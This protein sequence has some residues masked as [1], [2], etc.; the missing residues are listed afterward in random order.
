M[1]GYGLLGKGPRLH[2]SLLQ[3]TGRCTSGA[4]ACWVRGLVFTR[5]RCRAASRRVCSVATSSTRT[6]AS[7]TCRRRC[8]A[9]RRSPVR[10]PFKWAAPSSAYF[11]QYYIQHLSSVHVQ[12][13]SVLPHVL[14]LQS[15]VD[16]CASAFIEIPDT[17]MCTPLNITSKNIYKMHT[18]FF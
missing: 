6:L 17:C 10:G 2:T 4:T 13:T 8:T 12:T 16:R 18:D 3:M 9:S 15:R 7:S 14:S 1:W 11:S 5:V